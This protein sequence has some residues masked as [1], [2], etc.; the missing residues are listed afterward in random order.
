MSDTIFLEL[1]D[2][3]I[4]KMSALATQKPCDSIYG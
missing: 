4:A 3:F 2:I 1:V